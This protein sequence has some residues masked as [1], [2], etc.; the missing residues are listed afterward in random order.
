MRYLEDDDSEEDDLDED[1]LSSISRSLS[2]ARNKQKTKRQKGDRQGLQELPDR[3]PRK[4]K[5]LD[6]AT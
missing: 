1:D 4:D 3:R 5:K 6:E 2:V